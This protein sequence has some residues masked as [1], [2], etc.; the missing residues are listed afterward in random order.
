VSTPNP[1]TPA[2]LREQAATT[3]NGIVA[4]ELRVRALELEV[5]AMNDVHEAAQTLR[6]APRKKASA[7]RARKAK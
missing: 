2:S 5:A 6:A 3:A 7:K 1:V 4:L